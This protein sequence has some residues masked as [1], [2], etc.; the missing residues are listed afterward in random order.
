MTQQTCTDSNIMTKTEAAKFLEI[1]VRTIDSWMQKGILPF[2][3]MPTGSVRFRRSQLIEALA[4]FE[5]NSIH[6]Q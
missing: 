1:S 6:A 2:C 4:R 3:K 5:V